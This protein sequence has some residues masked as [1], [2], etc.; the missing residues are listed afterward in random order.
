MAASSQ[1][2]SR[3]QGACRRARIGVAPPLIKL[4]ARRGPFADG[5]KS[6]SPSGD[7]RL[8][9]RAP[10]PAIHVLVNSLLKTSSTLAAVTTSGSNSLTRRRV[11]PQATKLDLILWP[12]RCRTSMRTRVN[13]EGRPFLHSDRKPNEHERTRTGQTGVEKTAGAWI[14]INKVRRHKQ[15]V[16]AKSHNQYRRA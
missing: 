4:A 6:I 15:K 14:F 10:P 3:N 2:Q 9:D 7:L 13:Q 8:L 5:A 1:T 11:K 16:S 12:D